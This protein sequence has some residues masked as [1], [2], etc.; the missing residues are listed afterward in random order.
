MNDPGK[1][2]KS[3]RKQLKLGVKAVY[4]KTG[5]GDSTIRR[6]EE[7]ATNIHMHHN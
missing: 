3:F 6:I 5:V 1:Y 2:L 4:A 7:G